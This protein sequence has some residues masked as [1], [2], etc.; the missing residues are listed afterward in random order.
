MHRKKIITYNS[1]NI[2]REKWRKSL[3][4][5]KKVRLLSKKLFN[6][7]DKH[8]FHYLQSWNGEVIIQ[9]PD[10]IMSIIEI[11]FKTKPEV[12]IETGVAWGGSLLMYHTLSKVIPIKKIIGIDI[13][14]PKDL[15]SRIKK[16]TNNSNKIFLIE[17][18]SVDEK[19]IDKI[20]KLTKAN[21]SFFIH[22][23]SNHTTEHV[24]KELLIYSKF[25]RSKNYLVVGDTIVAHIP[26]QKHRPRQWSKKNNPNIALKKFLIKNK[27][28]QID[29]KINYRQ[30]LTNQP[31]GYLVKK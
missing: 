28:F 11:I 10:D 25:L 3:Y 21:K 29:E 16:K 18:S 13:F 20:I 30:L 8:H 27:K 15:K 2:L 24:L 12:I 26:Y 23:D 5:D 9:T 7:A 19:L 22:L 4:K 31:K 6:L 1:F 17:G 14:I